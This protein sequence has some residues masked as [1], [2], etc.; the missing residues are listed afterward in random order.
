MWHSEQNG[1]IVMGS[2]SR[3]ISHLLKTF[4]ALSADAGYY[5][6][7][8]PLVNQ[9]WYVRLATMDYTST[10]SASS[11]YWHWRLWT[12]NMF[13]KLLGEFS[14]PP[15]IPDYSHFDWI[16]PARGP[17]SFLGADT[18]DCKLRAEMQHLQSRKRCIPCKRLENRTYRAGPGDI[19]LSAKTSDSHITW[20][21]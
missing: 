15:L 14:N 21:I 6:T 18:A 4:V 3:M 9:S 7:L 2:C 12:E 5:M 13:F 19:L 20:G 8:A 11:T 1:S 10:W 17:W 16:E